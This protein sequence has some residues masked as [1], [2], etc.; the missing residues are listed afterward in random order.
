M[1]ATN[2]VK[3]HLS[4]SSSLWDNIMAP[5]ADALGNADGQASEDEMMDLKC[6]FDLDGNE[7]LAWNSEAKVA[8][9]EIRKIIESDGT[10]NSPYLPNNFYEQYHNST[11]S[12]LSTN[13]ESLEGTN[14]NYNK[15]A[16]DGTMSNFLNV[17]EGT[18]ANNEVVDPQ[19]NCI[20]I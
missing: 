1:S 11:E 17:V 14:V 6:R 13:N 15:D 2:S 3:L 9:N 19:L 8:V 20:I 16:I 5:F 12:F 18:Y 10:Y 4:S 7:E